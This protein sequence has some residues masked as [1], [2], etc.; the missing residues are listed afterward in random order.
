MSLGKTFLKKFSLNQDL[1]NRKELVGEEHSKS[2]EEHIKG[3]LGDKCKEL[4]LANKET[5]YGSTT[6]MWDHKG[7]IDQVKVFILILKTMS[8]HQNALHKR[9]MWS[10]LPSEKIIQTAMW[11]LK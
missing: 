9:E 2:R 7:L 4:N 3:L 8:Q 10:D 6:R 1:K 5:Q 11:R